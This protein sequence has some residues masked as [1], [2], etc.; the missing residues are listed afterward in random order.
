MQQ[1]MMALIDR[2]PL[3]LITCISS[4]I[5]TRTDQRSIGHA[6]HSTVRLN[7]LHAVATQIETMQ[8]SFTQ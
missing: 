7:V 3:L 6:K 5:L 4:A 2:I 1:D 8:F